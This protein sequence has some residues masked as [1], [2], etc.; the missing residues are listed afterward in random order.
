[1]KLHQI[2]DLLAVAQKGSLRAAARHLRVAQ[3]SISRSI[4]QLERELGVALLE[5]QARGTVLTASGKLF[6]RRASAAASELQRARDELEQLHGAG[7]GSVSA[8]F[9]SVPLLA[10]LPGALPPFQKRYPRVELRIVES[11]FPAIEARLKDGTVDFYSG[12]SPDRM[13]SADL[14]F[15]KLFNNTRVVLARQGHPLS[16]A[17]SLAELAEARWVTTSITDDAA[18]EIADLF[19]LH[20]LPAPRLGARV[21]GGVLGLITMLAYTDLLA[22]VPQQWTQ[23]SPVRETLRRLDLKEELAAPPIC[24]IR[25]AALPLTPAAEFLCDLLR[26]SSVQYAGTEPAVRRRRLDSGRR[27]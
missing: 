21:S 13:P 9:S 17:K 4:G 15:E 25:R 3:P 11:A 10:L 14:V 2:R 20:G 7:E 12:V 1:M 18:A 22:I 6:A 23:F 8:A 16:N 5:R 24:I 19:K 26:R 27:P